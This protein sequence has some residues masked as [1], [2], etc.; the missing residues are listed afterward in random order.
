MCSRKGSYRLARLADKYGSE[1]DMRELL[2]FLAGDCRYWR[3]RHPGIEGCGAHFCDLGSGRPP[4]LPPGA[5]PRLRV[6]K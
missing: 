3:P 5:S 1:I 2:E 4:D 6:V